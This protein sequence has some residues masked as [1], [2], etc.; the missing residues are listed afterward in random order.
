VAHHGKTTVPQHEEATCIRMMV[1]FRETYGDR[2]YVR[3]A[4]EISALPYKEWKGKV[5]H[6]LRCHGV[7]GKGPHDVWVPQ[8]MLWNLISFENYCCVYHHGDQLMP[9]EGA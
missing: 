2:A 6:R 3:R 9:R 7:R 5:V 4:S 8:S 1:Y